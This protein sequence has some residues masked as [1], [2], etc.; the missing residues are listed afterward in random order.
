MA[1]PSPT[2]RRRRLAA[3]LRGLREAKG[4][5]IEQVAQLMEVSSSKISRIET[6]QVSTRLRDVRDLLDIYEV[7]DDRRDTLL[8]IARDARQRTWLDAFSDL[9]FAAAADMEGAASSMRLYSA[10]VIPGL[11]QTPDYARAVIR[12]IRVD[13]AQDVI[14]RM[15]ELRRSRQSILER[16]DSPAI[17]V[18]LDEAVLRR[19]VGGPEVQRAQLHRLVEVTHLPR[20]TLQ[21]LPFTAGAHAGLD[22]EF[23]IIGFQEDADQD[24]VYIEN[25]TS[26][27]YLESTA[28]IRQYSKLFD[29][30][31][32]KAI[33]PAHS[34]DFFARVAKELS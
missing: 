18:V 14:D 23:T 31:R 15:V 9:P 4:L 29:H 20:V 8:K 27:L 10:L 17:W 28:E 16:E 25:T 7:Q 21:V 5:T 32:A 1:G 19:L 2:V 3:E 24:V 6:A 22:G 13:S 11:L 30:L 34:A 12:A 33:D 26:E